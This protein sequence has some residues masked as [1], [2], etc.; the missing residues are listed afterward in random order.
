MFGVSAAVVAFVTALIFVGLRPRRRPVPSE[1]FARTPRWVRRLV[2][3]GGVVFPVIVLSV[4]WVL[5]LRDMRALSQPAGPTELTID[6]IGHQWWWEVRY[7]QQQ[8]VTAN[9]IH[10]PAGRTVHLVLTTQDVLHSFWVPE[11]TGKTDL[12][13]GRTNSMTVQADHPGVYRGQC[14]EF[15]G[16]QHANMAFYVIA[17]S[18][19]DFQQWLS[20]ETAAPTSSRD[21]TLLRGQQVFESAACSA[22][23]TIRGTTARGTVGPDLSD[24]GSRQSIGA[25]T[26]PNTR[27]NLGGWIVD[28]QTIKPGNLMPPMQLSSGDLRALIAYLQS[29]R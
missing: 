1:T 20:T 17:Q 14:A 15:C 6:V 8:I 28:S 22:C 9:D 26:L 27:G 24:F 13:S 19:S 25:G 5:T 29:L 18:P 7:P 3:G 11:L 23:H 2:L 10:I 21:P 16:L 4:L 12:I